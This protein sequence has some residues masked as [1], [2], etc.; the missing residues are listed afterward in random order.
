MVAGGTGSHVKQLVQGRA[1][2]MAEAAERTT[3]ALRDRAGQAGSRLADATPS[4]GEVRQSAWRAAGVVQE[5]PLG[6]A[7]GAA[8]AGFLAGLLLPRTRVEEERLGR[9]RASK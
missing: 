5:N 3:W 6:F 9:S 4:P 2:E 1:R 8:A 7:I